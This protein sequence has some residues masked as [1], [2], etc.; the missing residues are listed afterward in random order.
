MNMD[1]HVSDN[2]IRF[3]IFSLNGGRFSKTGIDM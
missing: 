3:T 1:E 2:D